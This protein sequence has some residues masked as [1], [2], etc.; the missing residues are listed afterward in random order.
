MVL[1][2]WAFSQ[3]LNVANLMKKQVIIKI[4]IISLHIAVKA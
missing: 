2:K 4:I 1:I 3:I